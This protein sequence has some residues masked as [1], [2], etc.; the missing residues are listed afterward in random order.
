M[1]VWIPRCTS[2]YSCRLSQGYFFAKPLSDDAASKYLGESQGA[3]AL[4]QPIDCE[5][6]FGKPVENYFM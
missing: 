2:Q 4:V 1:Q 3:Q 5:A 6:R